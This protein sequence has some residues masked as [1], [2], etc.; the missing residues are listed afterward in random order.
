MHLKLSDLWRWEGTIDRGPYALVGVIGFALK[1]NLDRFVA[2]FIFHRRWDIFNY[3]IPPEKAMQISAFSKD[4]AL[5]CIT[6]VAMALPFIWV[7]VVL[8][9]KR[10]RAAQLPSWLVA[11]FFVPFI[12]LIF[13]LLLSILPS[14]EGQ[15]P[16]T[17]ER[18]RWI[19]SRLIPDHPI[20][21][22]AMAL[23]LTV[24]LG[25]AMTQLGVKGFST[26]GWGLFVGLP[27]CSG[28]L[29][30]LLYGSRRPRSYAGC[31]SVSLLSILLLGVV[32]LVVAIEG[33][34]CLIMA[35][36]IAAALAIIGGSVGYVIQRRPSSRD[37]APSMLLL[38]VLLVPSLMGAEYVG[39]LQA[40]LLE[41][42]T[43]IEI[44][45]PLEQVWRQVVSFSEL[46]EPEE[47]LFR[48]GIAYPVRAKI[49]GKGVGAERHCVFSTGS[50]IEPIKVW[51]EPRLLK[52]AV[53]KNPPPMEEWTPYSR[54]HPPH[55]DGFLMSEQGQFFLV[56][57]VD[58]RTRLEGTT[59]YRHHM[60]PA[61]YWQVWSDFMIHQIH[62]RVLRHIKTLAESDGSPL[63]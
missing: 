56:P 32:L 30:V 39:Q 27:F 63:G 28:F 5:F 46:P 29:S 61:R 7:G 24:S 1:H 9:L 33:V 34:I 58:G 18:G 12:N 26:Y 40:P 6:M 50:F 2:S 53:T 57:T 31:L 55:L 23:L 37:E 20:G 60:W 19:L 48:H 10:L 51:D 62:L 44:N 17:A 25:V 11:I 47:W 38:L 13:F 43:A 8:T 42:R 21:S 41:V 36:P 52:F 15:K 14:R 22:A 49:Y 4:E 45:A 3:W 16:P 35:A 59:W 54:L